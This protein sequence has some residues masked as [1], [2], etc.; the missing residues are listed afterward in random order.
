LRPTLIGHAPAG[1]VHSVAAEPLRQ[2]A[3]LGLAA[4]SASTQPVSRLVALPL[5]QVSVDLE[6]VVLLAASWQ[7]RPVIGRSC[8]RNRPPELIVL[9]VTGFGPFHAA[10]AGAH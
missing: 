5:P 9:M 4:N 8:M 6:N 2:H 1:A 3:G 10:V 7:A